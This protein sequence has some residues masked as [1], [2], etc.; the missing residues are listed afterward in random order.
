MMLAV[1]GVEKGGNDVFATIPMV[2]TEIT[3]PRSFAEVKSCPCREPDAD[4]IID[5]RLSKLYIV[6]SL[7]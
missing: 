4:S 7:C 1:T 6:F 5:A 3:R 2:F